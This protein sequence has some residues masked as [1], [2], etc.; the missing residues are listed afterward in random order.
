M[1]ILIDETQFESDNVIL[2]EKNTNTIMN[3]GFFHRIY[4]S[5][6][7]FTMNGVYLLY[8][9]TNIF[10]QEDYNKISITI[11]DPVKY[12]LILRSIQKIEGLIADKYSKYI[13]K[14]FITKICDYFTNG[15]IK[16]FNDI[17]I[18]NGKYDVKSLVL[19]ISGVW[20]TDYQYGITFK[21]LLA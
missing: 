5:T 1:L 3:N 4:Y 10:V 18:K 8:N 19:K 20:E 7:E 17:N 21:L 6:P 11:L 13:N 2:L 16:L 14:K 9:L 12:N 15:K